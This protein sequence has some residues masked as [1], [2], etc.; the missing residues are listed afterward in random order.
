MLKKYKMSIII[1]VYNRER[2]IERCLESCLNQNLDS[3]EIV[4]VDDCSIDKSVD[5][6]KSFFLNK[7]VN[8][9]ILEIDKNKGV[10]HARNFGVK[11]SEGEWLLFLD[12]DDELLTG[13]LHTILT[14]IDQVERHNP[15]IKKLG[16]PYLKDEKKIPAHAPFSEVVNF[17]N[18]LRWINDLR[19]TDY[20]QVIHNDI[21]QQFKWNEE[22]VPEKEFH[23]KL[24][25]GTDLFY[26]DEIVAKI[27]SDAEQQLTRVSISAIPYQQAVNTYDSNIRIL[28][29]Y[30]LELKG[31]APR[32][33]ESIIN[34][35]LI[36]ALS[37]D[38]IKEL[39]IYLF[40]NRLY[41]SLN[42]KQ[43]FFILI[44]I[45]N[46][47]IAYGIAEKRK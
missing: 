20:L 9:K 45:F 15:N 47:R 21:F 34:T 41:T 19:G 4:I 30:S 42:K 6:V 39:A 37:A 36:Y 23:L 29:R 27:N 11:S 10:G 17:V 25:D 44:S 12:S 8:Y 3:V 22:R 1:P 14:T 7:R 26:K 28:S 40:K 33:L 32:M 38:K 46:S 16:F 13:K 43:F 35:L 24:F 2:E 5:V 31:Y 18:Y